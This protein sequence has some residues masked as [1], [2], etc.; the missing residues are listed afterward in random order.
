ML[1]LAALLLGSTAALIAWATVDALLAATRGCRPARLLVWTGA[2][3]TG[4]IVPY[5]IIDL[6]CSDD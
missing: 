2:I 5:L 1:F 6:F 4:A 3:A